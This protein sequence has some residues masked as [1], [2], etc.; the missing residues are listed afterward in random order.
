MYGLKQASL[1]WNKQVHTSLVKLDFQHCLS[2]TGVYIHRKGRKYVIVILYVDDVLFIRNDK[3]YN[4]LKKQEFMKI[5][6][7]RDLGE[8]KEFLGMRITRDRKNKSIQLDQIDYPKKVVKDLVLKMLNLY[9]LH[10]LQDIC[11]KRIWKKK[12]PNLK[13][14]INK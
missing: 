3:K 7:C 8:A 4:L 14:C 9:A 6:E 1:A 10:Y 2:N 12:I 5:W 13:N 11:Q